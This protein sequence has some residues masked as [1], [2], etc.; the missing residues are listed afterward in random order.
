MRFRASVTDQQDRTVGEL[1]DEKGRSGLCLFVCFDLSS[2]HRLQGNSM[3]FVVSGACS[4]QLNGL[5]VRMF[6]AAIVSGE[7]A[8]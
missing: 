1:P 4:C 2:D 8:E 3:Y 5:E 6:L 7:A